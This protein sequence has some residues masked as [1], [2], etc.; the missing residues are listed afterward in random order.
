MIPEL[1]L[2]VW[3]QTA[4]C[5]TWPTVVDV[6]N[7]WFAFSRN[8]ANT[9]LGDWSVIW[10][11][12]RHV[13]VFG[14]RPARAGR[15]Q[16]LGKKLRLS[17]NPGVAAKSSLVGDDLRDIFSMCERLPWTSSPRTRNPRIRSVSTMLIPQ[18][19]QA[20]LCKKKSPDLASRGCF[21]RESLFFRSYSTTC[22]VQISQPG[23]WPVPRF[24]SLRKIHNQGGEITSNGRSEPF[25]FP[26]LTKSNPTRPRGVTDE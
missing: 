20:P 22:W 2:L 18:A 3:N 5:I 6:D 23:D 14:L 15:V 7:N 10:A 11:C 21:S 24:H 8:L 25:F 12:G 19:Q 13:M 17:W 16:S 9:S 26:K 1:F 4:G